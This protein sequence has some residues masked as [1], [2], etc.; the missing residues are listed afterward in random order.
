MSVFFIISFRRLV[1][2]DKL[3]A[4]ADPKTTRR[5]ALETMAIGGAVG[6]GAVA[7]PTVRFL[8]A[9]S[10]GAACQGRWIKTVPLDALRDGEPKRVALVADH[11][12]AWTLE[13]DVELGAAWLVR[14][15]NRVTAWSSI[16]PHLGCAVDR[17]GTGS[18]F[19][20]PCHDSSFDPAGR[21]LTGPSPRDLDELGTR[22]E[23]GHVLVEFRR[24]RQGVTTK[25]PV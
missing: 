2:H 3:A 9:P 11:H 16:C 6:C 4:V 5:R 19:Y 8:L 15:G 20:C 25:E 10:S 18:G 17:G 24:F 22:V 23:A 14:Q 12:D 1:L 13:R 7:A 21:R